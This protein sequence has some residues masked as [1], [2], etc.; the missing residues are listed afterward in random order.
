M[1][2]LIHQ[3]EVKQVLAEVLHMKISS[4]FL[5]LVF[6]CHTFYASTIK[7]Q[8]RFKN[9]YSFSSVKTVNIPDCRND[10]VLR[11]LTE[12][13][14]ASG[15]DTFHPRTLLD[16][17]DLSDDEYDQMSQVS[18]DEKELYRTMHNT[19]LNGVEL[20][21]MRANIASKKKLKKSK[22]K[23]ASMFIDIAFHKNKKQNQASCLHYLFG[24]SKK[25]DIEPQFYD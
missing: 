25:V 9:K 22:V 18:S 6:C 1:I 24:F 11:T 17:P 14:D 19:S 2:Y 23:S 13:S 16:S 15:Y 3:I 10:V 21:S 5:V 8:V 12:S 20:L 4:L 7:K